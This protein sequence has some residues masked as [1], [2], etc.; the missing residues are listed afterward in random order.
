MSV[1]NLKTRC[2]YAPC[3]CHMNRTGVGREHGDVTYWQPAGVDTREAI[4][5]ASIDDKA[6]RGKVQFCIHPPERQTSIVTSV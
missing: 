6:Y 5:P 4:I 3:F 2:T 1:S